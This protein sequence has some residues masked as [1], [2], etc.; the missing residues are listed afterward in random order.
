MTSDEEENKLP[1]EASWFSQDLVFRKDIERLIEE[2]I[3][4]LKPCVDQYEYDQVG[5]LE[6]L[7]EE[8]RL[9]EE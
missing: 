5:I 6:E 1:T 8:V 2:K 7:L 9:S 4:E 3:E